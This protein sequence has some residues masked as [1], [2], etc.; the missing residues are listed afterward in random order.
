MFILS[1]EKLALF[2]KTKIDIYYFFT[3]K[4]KK[5]YIPRNVFMFFASIYVKEY[6][7]KIKAKDKSHYEIDL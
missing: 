4:I 2:A 7:L 1:N 6:F 3:K 5:K